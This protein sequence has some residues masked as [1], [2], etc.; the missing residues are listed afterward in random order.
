L[1][2][3]ALHSS[4]SCAMYQAESLGSRFLSKLYTALVHAFCTASSWSCSCLFSS[5]RAAAAAAASSSSCRR[6]SASSSSSCKGHHHMSSFNEHVAMETRVARYLE[7]GSLLGSSSLLLLLLAAASCGRLL[8]LQLQ[9]CQRCCT[10]PV[11]PAHKPKAWRCVGRDQSALK[12][13]TSANVHGHPHPNTDAHRSSSRRCCSSRCA[14]ALASASCRCLSSSCACRC[15][16]AAAFGTERVMAHIANNAKHHG[17]D[18]TYLGLSLGLAA[19]P[20][21]AQGKV[22]PGLQAR[23]KRDLQAGISSLT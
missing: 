10:A 18:F 8:A 3:S 17:N 6:F 20:T 21:A 19:L 11:S 15:R 16:S 9:L 5:S 12:T 2:W 22:S 4:S 14:L 13:S 1:G 7:P 23:L